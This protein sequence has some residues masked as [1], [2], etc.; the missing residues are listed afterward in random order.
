M[1]WWLLRLTF[2][3]VWMYVCSAER[4]IVMIETTCKR[5]VFYIQVMR[6]SFAFNLFIFI[7]QRRQ[8]RTK[9]NYIL[10][11]LL[12]HELSTCLIFMIIIYSEVTCSSTLFVCPAVDGWNVQSEKKTSDMIIHFVTISYL[13]YY[14]LKTFS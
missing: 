7:N 2:D 4:S 10:P 8:D 11:F 14:F 13:V 3:E 1:Y 12:L 5:S 9:K 6:G